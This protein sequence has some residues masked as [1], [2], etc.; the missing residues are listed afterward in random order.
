MVAEVVFALLMNAGSKGAFE[1]DP[2]M[3][4]Q[5]DLDGRVFFEQTFGQ[6]AFYRIKYDHTDSDDEPENSRQP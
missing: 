1:G 3:K 5:V 4:L 2:I 6:R